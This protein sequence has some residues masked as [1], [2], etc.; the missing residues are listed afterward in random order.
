MYEQNI[1][2][3]MWH[4]NRFN[5]VEIRVPHLKTAM[6]V[7]VRIK[8]TGTGIILFPQWFLVGFVCVFVCWNKTQ[9]TILHILCWEGSKPPGSDHTRAGNKNRNKEHLGYVSVWSPRLGNSAKMK[10]KCR[11]ASAG[12]RVSWDFGLRVSWNF[13]LRGFG[14]N[15][16]GFHCHQ[17]G[18][19]RRTTLTNWGSGSNIFDYCM[20]HVRY[21]VCGVCREDWQVGH[22]E[23]KS[24]CRFKSTHRLF[25][26]L[27]LVV[28]R[29]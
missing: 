25:I 12:E 9:Q 6:G 21:D 10:L 27:L 19:F 16:T 3:K 29:F 15:F 5:I 22:G 8:W 24:F 4:A 23:D 11:E 14:C 1:V 17:K 26:L 7:S 20:C 18:D 28:L 2:R 13:G